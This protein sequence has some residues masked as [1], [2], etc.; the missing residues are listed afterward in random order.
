M[1]ELRLRFTLPGNADDDLVARFGPQTTVGQLADEIARSFDPAEPSTVRPRTLVR[2]SRSERPFS[3]HAR[4]SQIDLR[5]GDSVA[6][7]DD[8]DRRPDPVVPAVA[9]LRIVDGPGAGRVHELRRGESTVGR[10]PRC[11]VPLIDDLASRRHA[12]IRVTDVVEVA[13]A[14]STNGIAVNGTLVSGWWR[15]RPG[16]RLLVGDT[17]MVIELSGGDQTTA[18]MIDNAVA[19]NRPPRLMEAVEPTK[20]ELPAPVEPPA[21]QSFPVTAAVVP[22]LMGALLYAIT[23]SVASLAFIALSPA[24]AAGSLW[25]QRRSAR[26]EHAAHRADQAAVLRE[27]LAQLDLARDTEVARR[28]RLSPG[29]HQQVALAAQQ[30]ERLWERRAQDP[31]FLAL[32]LG[33]RSLPS[34][35]E[36]EVQP[37]GSHAARA[38][39]EQVAAAY[40]TL[41]PVPVTVDAAGQAPVALIGPAELTDG[42]ARS[43]LIQAATLHSPR[44]LLIGAL[45]PESRQAAWEWLK[46]LPHNARP[47]PGTERRLDAVGSVDGVELVVALD[48]LVAGRLERRGGTGREHPT[49]EPHLL[50][51]VDG[52]AGIERSR[53]ARL[54]EEG[55]SVGVSL[56][57]L[58]DDARQVPHACNT[59]ITAEPGLH[60]VTVA[61]RAGSRLG[62]VPVETVSAEAADAAARALAPLVDLSA[63]APDEAALPT[64]V[65]LVDLLGGLDVLDNPTATIERWRESSAGRSLRAPL[66]LAADGVVSV[67]LREDGPHALVGGTTGAG[68]SELLQSFLA[69]LA[70]THSPERLNFLL[71]DYKGGSAFGDLV[72]RVD[73][74]GN[75]KWSGLPHSVGLITD[76]SPALAQRA[77]TSL[78]AELTRREHIL[79]HHRM[80]DLAEMAAAGVPGTPASLLIVI[81][82]FA[83]LAREVPAF[84]DGVVDVAARGRSLGLHLLLATQKPGGVVTPAIQANTS[85]RI[86]LRM[87]SDDESHDVIASPL[88]GRLSR[89]TPGRGVIRKGPG[90]LVTFQSAYVGGVTTPASESSLEVGELSLAGIRWLTSSRAKATDTADG[91]SDLRR[92]VT[93]INAAAEQV[94]CP[95]PGRPWLDPLPPALD[96]LDLPR[97]ADD[98][99]FAFGLADLPHQQAREL[100]TFVPDRDGSLA[101]FGAG[102]AGKTVALRTLAAA[103]GLAKT[104]APVHVYALD[105]AGRG[106]DLVEPL[107][108]VGS[109]IPGDDYERVT[110]LLRELKAEIDRRATLFAD[111]RASSMA[112]YRM[113][114]PDGGTLARVVILLDGYDNFLAA[115]ESLDR[116]RWAELMPRLV[117]DGRSLGVHFVVTASRRSSLPL[118][119]HSAIPARLVMRL[120]NDDEYMALGADPVGFD[121]D[122]P[123][124]R[125]RLGGTE[126]Q[127]AVLGGNPATA[128]E[129]STFRRLGEALAAILP[130][131]P[132]VRVLPTEVRLR[133]LRAAKSGLAWLLTDDFDTIGP[134]LSQH[135]L[136]AGRA[137][138][139]KST[140]LASLAEAARGAGHGTVEVYAADPARCPLPARDLDALAER[141]AADATGVVMID[142]VERVGGSAA[143]YPLQEAMTAGGL[144]VVATADNTAARAYDPTIKAIRSRC[145]VLVLQPDLDLDGDLLGQALARTARQFPPGRGY[146]RILDQ[147]VVVQTA[148]P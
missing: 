73:S 29:P 140:A 59:T 138:S 14:G 3:R 38:E 95:E 106:L 79:N 60:T 120:A 90:E 46:W 54:L 131:A 16:D 43:L 101:L 134:D 102:G 121:L 2:V 7:A 12:M 115:Y 112:E 31:D 141:L 1:S 114:G 61:S 92:L 96:L 126:V 97:P 20:V 143:E 123:P 84:V 104:R 37:G 52:A 142:G 93:V 117:A 51:L 137:R 122:T 8:G 33:L 63:G 108:H 25:E 127:V 72:D 19:F 78:Q 55:P 13:D 135:V 40:S 76:L 116:G 66:G 83:A 24:M 81:D 44:D 94:A 35:I 49:T 23:G 133:E 119:L 17:T 30:S 147:V 53:L 77:L 98:T 28:H 32:R 62:G 125:A 6:L 129:A 124:G 42:I 103:L 69:A 5:S 88:A 71:V 10:S 91:P 47:L 85:L 34:L 136:I 113:A 11:D 4:L 27:R 75:L 107:P 22:L 21:R 26:R 118:S 110:R 139:G 74:Q 145:D 82:E 86:A 111:A 45:V 57:W 36:V 64:A 144:R 100:A 68:K 67:D 80:K 105:F 18:D 89:R 70:A 39:L 128:L 48:Q 58:S 146:A 99:N 148:L 9:R 56:L 109:V 41:P 87:A 132:P 130:A 50:V 15:L 65:N